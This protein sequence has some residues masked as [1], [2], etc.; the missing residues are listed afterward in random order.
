M[1]VSILL[2]LIKLLS[3]PILVIQDEAQLFLI[4]IAPNA[5]LNPPLP[6]F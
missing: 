2:G 4:F 1:S 6:T 5:Y 3:L